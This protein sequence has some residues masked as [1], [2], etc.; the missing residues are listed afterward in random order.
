MG[1]LPLQRSTGRAA[2]LALCVCVLCAARAAHANVTKK[3]DVVEKVVAVINDDAVFLSDLRRRAAPFLETIATQ[4]APAERR[5]H[6]ERLYERLLGQLVDEELIQ[7][8]ANTMHVAITSLEIEQAI[9]NVRNQNGMSAEQFWEAVRGQGFTEQGYRQDVRKQLLRLKVLNQRVRSR[10]QIGED[11]VRATYDDQV[12]AAR[13]SQRFRA[14][15]VFLPLS[16]EATATEVA[17]ALSKAAKIR[18]GLTVDD[19]DAAIAEHGGGDLG[20]LDQGDLPTALEEAL[21]E[22]DA[23]EIG[24]PVRGPS[25][26]HV[27]LVR[28]RQAGEAQL[29]SYDEAR[30]QIHQALMGRAL[31]KQEGL[32]LSELRRK[33]VIELRL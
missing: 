25:G 23:G 11:E 30:V 5:G 20:W 12:R 4:V 33:A 15:H 21:L 10:V 14:A 28:E 31:Q 13:R 2:S 24:Q 7:Q 16:A 27:F 8:T 18:A 3:P 19:F 26:I 29:P 9:D 6:V 1:S 32:F 17:E 22:L